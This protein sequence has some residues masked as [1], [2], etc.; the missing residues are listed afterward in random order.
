VGRKKEKRKRKT[1]ATHT[2]GRPHAV[3][4]VRRVKVWVNMLVVTLI[5]VLICVYS[6]AAVSHSLVFS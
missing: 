4:G 6:K 1:K 5:P 3:T 2:N